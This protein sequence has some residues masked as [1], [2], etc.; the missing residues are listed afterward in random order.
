MG[1]D[2]N[3]SNMVYNP[4]NGAYYSANAYSGMMPYTNPD[5]QKMYMDPTFA[6][7]IQDYAGQTNPYDINSSN[8][9]EK[10]RAFDWFKQQETFMKDGRPAALDWKKVPQAMNYDRNGNPIGLKDAYK[11]DPYTISNPGSV[12]FNDLTSQLTGNVNGVNLDKAALNSLQQYGLNQ[13]ASPWLQMQLENQKRDEQNQMN[14]AT[15]QMAGSDAQARTNL[16][17]KGGLSSGARE[18]LARSGALGLNA[19]KQNIANAGATSRLGLNIQDESNKL[20]ILKQLPGLQL[21]ASNFDLTKA[22]TA[23]DL[24]LKE[25]GVGLDTAFKNNQQATDIAKYNADQNSA[26]DKF[27]SSAA[28]N[29]LLQQRAFESNKYNEAMKAWGAEKTAEATG[30]GGKK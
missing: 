21:G 30:S 7:K 10:Q 29:E 1:A 23:N 28:L 19:T 12:Q 3:P 11:L 5:L 15:S 20:D 13:G 17:L 25:Q 27:N 6:Q 18:R 14:Q 22:N 26:A 2:S 16:A 9:A 24:A 8:P 4:N